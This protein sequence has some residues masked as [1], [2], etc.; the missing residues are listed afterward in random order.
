MGSEITRPSGPE[1]ELSIAVVYDNYLVN[2]ELVA[3]WGF[4]CVIKTPTERILFDTGG[5]SSILLSNMKGM[6]IPPRHIEVVVISHADGDHLGGLKGFLKRNGEVKVYVPVSFPDSIKE[7]IESFGAECYS[8]DKATP[9]GRDVYSTGEM[10]V[11]IREQSLLLDARKGVILITGCAHPGIVN[12]IKRAKEIRPDRQIHLVMG[13]FHLGSADSEL[14]AVIKE[15]R[16]LGVE[17]TGPCHCSGGRCRELFEEEYEKDYVDMGV[18]K[19]IAF[20]N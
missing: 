12:I 1:G 10:G 16:R 17:R 18:G 8:V 14:R 6:K 19:V 4:S 9:I 13:G 2:P 11:W 15:F 5:Q 7:E 3:R 20:E